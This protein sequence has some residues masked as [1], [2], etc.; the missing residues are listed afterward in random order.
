MRTILSIMLLC[1]G[2]MVYAV[3][4]KPGDTLQLI[5]VE[6]VDSG[7]YSDLA[8]NYSDVV[9]KNNTTDSNV[10]LNDLYKF[11]LPS[12]QRVEALPGYKRTSLYDTRLEL[13]E[14]YKGSLFKPHRYG[15]T[16]YEISPR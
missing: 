7:L 13:T 10:G 9:V 16:I 3:D 8:V 11:T 14:S 4:M 2:L 12:P 1:F 6:L 15:S 5:D